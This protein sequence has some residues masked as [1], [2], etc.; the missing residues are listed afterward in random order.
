MLVSFLMADAEGIMEMTSLLL[1]TS[2]TIRNRQYDSLSRLAY[3]L[4]PL[5]APS[6]CKLVLIDGPLRQLFRLWLGVTQHLFR[7][8]DL[9]DD[10]LRIAIDDNSFRQ[11][12][13]EFMVAARVSLPSVGVTLHSKSTPRCNIALD[14]SIV[15]TSYPRDGAIV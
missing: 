2:V 4:W 14:T 9:L 8:P 3:Y 5:Q 13:L 6:S 7:K 12:D 11:D 10:V 1:C 15:L